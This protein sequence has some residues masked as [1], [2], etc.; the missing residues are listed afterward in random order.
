MGEFL[1]RTDDVRDS[2]EWGSLKLGGKR[3]WA[4]K[5]LEK[6]QEARAFYEKSLQ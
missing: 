5:L 4:D 2:C 3:G 1:Q 6:A